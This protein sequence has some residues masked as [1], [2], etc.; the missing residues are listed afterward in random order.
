ML[1]SDVIKEVRKIVAE[2]PNVYY[3]APEGGCQY[4]K[5]ECSDGSTGCLFGQVLTNLGEDVSRFDK[6]PAPEEYKTE[7][8]IPGIDKILEEFEGNDIDKTWCSLVQD[9]QDNGMSWE[10]AVAEADFEI[11]LYTFIDD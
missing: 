4:S 11:D 1:V 6:Y 3:Y 2:R 5:G 8:Y 9:G 7:T 10:D